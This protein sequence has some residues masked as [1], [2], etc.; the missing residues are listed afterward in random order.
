[1]RNAGRRVSGPPFENA[2]YAAFWRERAYR[3]KLPGKRAVQEMQKTVEGVGASSFGH[4]QHF[5]RGELIMQFCWRGRMVS[6]RASPKGYAAIWLRRHP[7]AHR[8]RVTKAEYERRA[9]EKGQLA[10]FSILRLAKGS[11]RRGRDRHS[12]LRSG[13][14]RADRLAKRRNRV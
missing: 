9:L 7:Y 3:T 5:D 1:M 12:Q 11:G 4:M 2:V 6:I 14:S 8:M 13:V 10:V